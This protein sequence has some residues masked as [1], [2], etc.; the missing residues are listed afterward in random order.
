MWNYGKAVGFVLGGV[1]LVALA[2]RAPA[3][4]IGVGGSATVSVPPADIRLDL[5]ESGTETRVWGEQTLVLTAA[6]SLDAINTGLVSLP[7]HAVP[8]V[9]P[10][11]TAVA[12]YMLRAD[13]IGNTDTSLSGFVLF[14]SPILGVL[15]NRP[16]LRDSDALL[17]LPGVTY[18]GN[19]DRGLELNNPTQD[20]F[21]ISA[22]RMRID[23]SYFVGVWTDD[24]RSRQ[25]GRRPT[26]LYPARR[27][28]TRRS[29]PLCIWNPSSR[30]PNSLHNRPRRCRCWQDSPRVS[31]CG[32]ADAG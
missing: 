2:S 17:G 30:L 15:I 10:S 9:V 4:I 23:F 19:T 28:C 12:S 7:E 18:N 1:G 32:R 11:G 21:T 22:D 24:I 29:L 25:V 26:P 27:V 20:F 14:D 16:T 13:P 3:G 5:W 31:A 6:L 8:G